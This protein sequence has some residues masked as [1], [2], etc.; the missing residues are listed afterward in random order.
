MPFPTL[1]ASP[2]SPAKPISRQQPAVE[3]RAAQ[4]AALTMRVSFWMKSA[5]AFCVTLSCGAAC[6][7][8][9]LNSNLNS[10]AAQPA[11]NAVVIGQKQ[12]PIPNLTLGF[13]AAA[14]WPSVRCCTTSDAAR[15]TAPLLRTPDAACRC[16]A[17]SLLTKGLPRNRL[18]DGCTRPRLRTTFIMQQRSSSSRARSRPWCKASPHFNR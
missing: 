15:Q 16:A 11:R 17:W 1:S 4:A 10:T 8:L 9:L 14:A 5:V 3:P 2:S 6:Y 18:R 12:N 7:L 13:G